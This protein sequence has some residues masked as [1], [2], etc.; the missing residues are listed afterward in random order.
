MADFKEV[1]VKQSTQQ[2]S[3]SL[4]SR[5]HAELSGVT[6]VNSFDEECVVLS[7]VCGE[8]TLEGTGLRVGTLDIARGVLAVDGKIS[9]LYYTDTKETRRKGFLG[10]FRR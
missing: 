3:L 8:L 7:T 4:S 6:E 10:S 1:S 5:E 9:G 2:H